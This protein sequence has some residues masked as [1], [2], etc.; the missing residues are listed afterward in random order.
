M[1]KLLRVPNAPMNAEFL[2]TSAHVQTN[3]LI[4]DCL[5]AKHAL[6]DASNAPSLMYASHALQAG[7]PLQYVF[8]AKG[9]SR[10]KQH[11]R[12]AHRIA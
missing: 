2:L 8:A 12:N 3:S 6:S 1:M 5:N 11:A 4:Q 7:L 9:S 10:S